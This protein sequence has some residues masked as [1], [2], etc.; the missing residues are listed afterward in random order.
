MN[1]AL[2]DDISDYIKTFFGK[3]GKSSGNRAF[4]RELGVDGEQL[5]PIVVIKLGPIADA[6]VGLERDP[7]PTAEQL[8]PSPAGKFGKGLE[9]FQF[10]HT[11]RP[12]SDGPVPILVVLGEKD[13]RRGW[14]ALRALAE[15]WDR[16]QPVVAT[17]RR[18]AIHE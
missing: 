6:R 18:S 7:V 16:L 14:R 12:A 17:L 15:P 9:F 3:Q 1:A 4:V 5:I 8:V 13:L 11:A 2:R 10:R